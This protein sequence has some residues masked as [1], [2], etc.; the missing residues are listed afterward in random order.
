MLMLILLGC[1]AGWVGVE[2]DECNGSGGFGG[3]KG[4]NPSFPDVFFKI[5]AQNMPLQV[6]V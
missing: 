4:S 2:E 5:Q 1:V 6:F 3:K